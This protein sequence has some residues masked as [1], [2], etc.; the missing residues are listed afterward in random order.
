MSR[1]LIFLLSAALLG[2]CS[3]PEAPTA[4]GAGAA[5]LVESAAVRLEAVSASATRSGSLRAQRE[6]HI[7]P[8]E[9][10][11]LVALPFHAGD[12]V[13]EGD[14]LLRLD[15]ALLIAEL[16][17]SEAQRRQLEVDLG[18]VERLSHSR[19]V[20]DEELSRARTAVDIALA[21]EQLLRTRLGYTRISAPFD[22]VISE[23]RAEPGDILQRYAHVLTLTD[24]SSLLTTVQVSELL[25]PHLA[26]GDSVSIQ[27]DALGV[28]R[29]PGKILRIFPSIDTATR[30][31]TVEVELTPVPPLARPGQLCRVSFTGR[32]QPR[33][34]IPFAAL[35]RDNLGEF[36][37]R[38]DEHDRAQR[39]AVVSGIKLGDDIE[40]LSGLEA[41]QRVVTKGFLGL[42]PG[43]AVRSVE[44]IGEAAASP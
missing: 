25:L 9:E 37:F 15:D 29:F 23:R 1:I 16:R 6:I 4:S 30:Q 27:I 41:G 26:V 19:L 14:L 39:Q 13:R 8:Q 32:P 36:A 10:G 44:R 17:K 24:L 43:S 21:E 3:E 18:R 28:E 31:G 20:S 34:L 7:L 33:L 5:Q 2:G 35:R 12:G 38:I 11:R 22:G 40:L 42:M